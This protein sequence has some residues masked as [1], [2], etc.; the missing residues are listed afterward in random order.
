MDTWGTHRFYVQCFG[1]KRDL[2][3]VRPIRAGRLVDVRAGQRDERS[4]YATNGNFRNL[5]LTSS[6]PL[7]LVSLAKRRE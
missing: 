7:L 3:G 2:R 1:K 4:L 5:G 6:A